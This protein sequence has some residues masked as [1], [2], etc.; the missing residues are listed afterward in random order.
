MD[1]LVVTPISSL[2]E[3][4][5]GLAGRGLKCADSAEGIRR[6][7]PTSMPEIQRTNLGNVVLQ[8]KAMGIH[9]FEVRLH[10]PPPVATLVGHAVVIRHE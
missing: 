7:L 5:I 9:D 4:E 6:G 2:G 10:G 8:L 3:A 1:S